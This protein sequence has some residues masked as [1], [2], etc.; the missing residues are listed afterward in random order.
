[1]ARRLISTV[2][3]DSS[4]TFTTLPMLGSFIKDPLARTFVVSGTTPSGTFSIVGEAQRSNDFDPSTEIG[5]W[6]SI[7]TLELLDNTEQAKSSTLPDP[8]AQWWI[9]GVITYVASLELNLIVTMEL[10]ADRTVY[11]TAIGL[12][13]SASV[14]DESTD[15]VLDLAKPGR[16]NK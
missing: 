1:M 10:W 3:V 8:Q 4:G 6:Q 12:D 7:G 2:T 15:L 5:T 9:R 16:Q 13:A 11:E 14:P